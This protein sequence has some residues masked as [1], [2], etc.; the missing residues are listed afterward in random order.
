MVDRERNKLNRW[1]RVRQNIDQLMTASM[2]REELKRKKEDERERK[3]AK[4]KKQHDKNT[5][6]KYK[7]LQEKRDSILSQMRHHM[8]SDEDARMR[9]HQSIV[10]EMQRHKS[11]V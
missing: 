6:E 3:L 1:Q 2:H 10:D 11:S 4:E 5:R 7:A 8:K 9:R